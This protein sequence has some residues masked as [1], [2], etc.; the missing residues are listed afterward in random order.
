M[1]TW[2]IIVNSFLILVI[3][4]ASIAVIAD[5]R[6]HKDDENISPEALKELRRSHF[7]FAMLTAVW[8]L[9]VHVV[10]FFS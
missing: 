10:R 3:L 8:L 9:F 7:I 6:K 2:K 4:A 5:Y 1:A